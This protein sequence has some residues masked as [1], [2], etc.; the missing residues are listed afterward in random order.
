M[1]FTLDILQTTALA[2][3]LY[4]LGRLI[5][6]KVE[7]LRKCCI[8]APVVG[9]LIFALLHLLTHSMGW[10]TFSFDETL[11]DVFMVI[12]FTSVGFTASFKMLKRGTKDVFLFLLLATT[13]V[14][15]QN[16]MAAGLATAFQ[17]DP[18]MGLAMGSIPMVGGHGT[19]GSFG[20]VLEDLGITG[21]T[22]VAVAAATYGLVAGSL[23]GGPIAKAKIN[24]FKLKSKVSVDTLYEVP[25]ETAQEEEKASRVDVNSFT[26]SMVL[27]IVAAGIGTYITLG[28]KK[29]GITLPVYIG[30][31]IIAVLVRNICDA[32]HKELPAKALD[33]WGNVSLTIFLSIA[34][35]SLRLWELAELAIPM[36]VV[37]LCQTLLMFLFASFVVYRVM[38]RDYEAA[39][40]TSAFCGFG[41]GA[42]PNAMAN[43]QAIVGQFGPAPTAFFVVPIVGGMFIDFTNTALITLFVNILH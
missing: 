5:V 25:G 36:I 38:G 40:M 20:P 9:G 33:I 19:S 34:L 11:K 41:M 35:M 21:A 14:I 7:F 39:V 29:I 28:F 30:G 26:T 43:M 6:S 42:T 2:L 12:F 3:L 8:P 27:L 22:T 15:L 17:L 18:R 37:L 24:K 23:M 32:S 16:L 10:L 31:M 1:T 13:M 4:C